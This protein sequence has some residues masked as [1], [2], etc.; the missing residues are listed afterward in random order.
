MRVRQTDRQKERQRGREA[1]RQ[2]GREAG[3]EN[4]VCVVV[5]VV[6]MDEP[7]SAC[8]DF[9]HSV[10]KN[11]NRCSM[12]NPTHHPPAQGAQTLALVGDGWRRERRAK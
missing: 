8:V 7:R 9:T 5:V 12:Y 10:A 4:K 6:E 11:E 1:E 3:R 2:G